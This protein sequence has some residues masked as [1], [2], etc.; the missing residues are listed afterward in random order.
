[1][2]DPPMNDDMAALLVRYY[3]VSLETA[4]ELVMELRDTRALASLTRP[5]GERAMPRNDLHGLKGAS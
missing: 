3:H 5:Y 2:E 1:M 4:C